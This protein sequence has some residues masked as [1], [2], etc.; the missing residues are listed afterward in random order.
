MSELLSYHV[1]VHAMEARAGWTPQR[2]FATAVAH[3]IGGHVPHARYIQ[4]GLA[5]KHDR[6]GEGVIERMID[7]WMTTDLNPAM[8]LLSSFRHMASVAEGFNAYHRSAPIGLPM[9]IALP[10]QSAQAP[11]VVVKKHIV[12]ADLDL[13]ICREGALMVANVAAEKL[14][15]A[16]QAGLAPAQQSLV[17]LAKYLGLHATAPGEVCE[18]FESEGYVPIARVAK[19]LGCH[20]RTLERR[21]RESGLSAEVLR[22]AS[23]LIKAVH[24]LGSKDSLTSIALDTGFSDLSHMSRAFKHSCGMTPSLCKTLVLNDAHRSAVQA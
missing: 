6:T 14:R 12:P 11:W 3:V 15:H 16:M 17:S 5:R 1:V 13:A 19:Q 10:Q 7:D 22:Q 21:L 24:R 4:A 8:L 20:Q 9:S 18:V 23:R 2:R